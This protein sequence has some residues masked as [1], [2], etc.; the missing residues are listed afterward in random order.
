MTQQAVQRQ[1]QAA[2]IPWID[3]TLGLRYEWT[4]VMEEDYNFLVPKPLV[5]YLHIIHL[6]RLI[7]FIPDQY[8]NQGCSTDV[9]IGF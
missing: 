5:R 2:A 6:H 7:N 9:S 3:L 1:S 4:A 8:C